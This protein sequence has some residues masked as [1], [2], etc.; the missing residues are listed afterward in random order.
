VITL[1]LYKNIYQILVVLYVPVRDR[2]NICSANLSR[3]YVTVFL[4]KWYLE[5]GDWDISNK[6][7]WA[8]KQGLVL[9][10]TGGIFLSDEEGFG[11]SRE[12]GRKCRNGDSTTTEVKVVHVR[13]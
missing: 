7:F 12:E 9:R 5:R 3:E 6:T 2:V 4:R 10:Q 13:E 11:I 1:D 8:R